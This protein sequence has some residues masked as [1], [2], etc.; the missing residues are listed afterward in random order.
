MTFQVKMGSGRWAVGGGREGK[1]VEGFVL[2]L[3]ETDMMNRDGAWGISYTAV[4]CSNRSH[5]RFPFSPC[6]FFFFFFFFRFPKGV[7]L[8]FVETSPYTLYILILFFLFFKEPDAKHKYEQEQKK[9]FFFKK[10]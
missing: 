6:F 5:K 8:F 10:K 4:S 2:S 9:V 7:M 3:S 1:G